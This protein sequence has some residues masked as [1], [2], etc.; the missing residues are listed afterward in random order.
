MGKH[1][2]L[3]K[4]KQLELKRQVSQ[5]SALGQ[6]PAIHNYSYAYTTQAVGSHQQLDTK[7]PFEY[8]YVTKDLV[9]TVFLSTSIV[10]FQVILYLLLKLHVLSVPFITY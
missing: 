3:E 6:T 4:K 7:I 9:K 1:K 5:P 8:A 10:A 2:T